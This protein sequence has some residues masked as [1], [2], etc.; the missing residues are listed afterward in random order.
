MSSPFFIQGWSISPDTCIP[1]KRLLSLVHPK[2]S[3]LCSLS[4]EL[5]LSLERCRELIRSSQ[6]TA[7]DLTARQYFAQS[8]LEAP[9]PHG[10][11]REGQVPGAAQ[12]LLAR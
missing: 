5:R 8:C 2:A 12:V 11:S 9:A 6:V 7:A 4:A 1:C 10:A 3:S